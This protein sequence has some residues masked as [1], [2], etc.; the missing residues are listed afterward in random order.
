MNKYQREVHLIIKT[1]IRGCK[2]YE[3]L[4]DETYCFHKKGCLAEIKERNI[5]TIDELKDYRKELRGLINEL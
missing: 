2:G 3:P 5:K 4:W 1:D